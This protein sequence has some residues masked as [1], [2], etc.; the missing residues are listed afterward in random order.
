M[1]R[2]SGD[3]ATTKVGIPLVETRNGGMTAA[4][5]A[6]DAAAASLPAPAISAILCRLPPPGRHVGSAPI[7]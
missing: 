6:I 4:A 7:C 1:K 2:T 3:G 5:A